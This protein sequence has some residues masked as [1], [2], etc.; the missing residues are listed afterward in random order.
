MAMSIVVTLL[1]CSFQ[2][3]AATSED[4]STYRTMLR[5]LVK[6]KGHEKASYRVPANPLSR[7]CSPITRCRDSK[8][9]PV[10]LRRHVFSSL[11]SAASSPQPVVTHR[12]SEIDPRAT[13]SL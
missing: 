5:E 11:R 6:E 2:L 3:R 8:K 9:P 10:P 12:E 13:A 1:I 7:G 4:V